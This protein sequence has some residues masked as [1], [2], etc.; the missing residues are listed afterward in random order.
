MNLF[1]LF[2]YYYISLVCKHTIVSHSLLR[3]LSSVN[4]SPESHVRPPL[5]PKL[6]QWREVS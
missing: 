3:D 4:G 1:L 6:L 5:L 2:E